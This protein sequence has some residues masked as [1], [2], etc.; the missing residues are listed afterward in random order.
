MATSWRSFAV[1]LL[2]MTILL[3]LSDSVHGAGR[4][5]WNKVTKEELEETEKV[6]RPE[7]KKERERERKK[8]GGG[9]HPRRTRT[10]SVLP[11]WPLSPLIAFHLQCWRVSCCLLPCALPLFC[12]LHV[13]VPSIPKDLILS[14]REVRK[15]RS[16]S[17]C[18]NTLYSNGRR[19]SGKH[20]Q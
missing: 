8:K 20:S 16:P 18:L 3:M 12:A 10:L 19:R 14:A 11:P 5:D 17:P 9:C 4:K 6:R 7:R 15:R 13:S 1:C 2:L